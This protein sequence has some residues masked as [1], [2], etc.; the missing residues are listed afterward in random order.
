MARNNDEALEL[1]TRSY[2]I[3][4]ETQEKFEA[5]VA[6]H[7]GT[8]NECLKSLILLF[9]LEESKKALPGF[10]VDIDN[11]R[12][13]LNILEESYIHLLQL[14]ADTTLR[15]R[16]E[17]STNLSTKDKTIASLQESLEKAKNDLTNYKEMY[18][19]QKGTA[20]KRLDELSKAYSALR[21]KERMVKILDDQVSELKADLNQAIDRYTAQAD[22]LTQLAALEAD[23]EQ[24]KSENAQLALQIVEL[25]KKLEENQKAADAAAEKISTEADDKL[26]KAL[27]NAAFEKEKALFALTTQH[28]DEI[29]ALKT[30]HLQ[31]M[32][33]LVRSSK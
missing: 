16:E 27:Q 32:Q 29:N 14:N 19:E 31:E 8:K 4:D 22:Q 25:Q 17:F 1:K 5:I 20:D 15:V 23:R 13:H 3:D 9:E 11:F 7:F 18:R 12:T 6:E 30:Q 2:R 10:S 28:Q 24:L 26:S 21:D 33:E